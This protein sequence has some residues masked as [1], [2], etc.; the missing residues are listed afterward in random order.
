MRS[1]TR[2]LRALIPLIGIILGRLLGAIPVIFKVHFHALAVKTVSFIRFLSSLWFITPL[3]SQP[4]AGGV[5]SLRRKLSRTVDQ[6]W[7]EGRTRGGVNYLAQKG[8]GLVE[9]LRRKTPITL[10]GVAVIAVYVPG[11]S[12]LFIY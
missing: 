6:G 1:P 3:T 10:L 7:L 2:L 12:W 9:S 8:A 11:L 4:G 5:L